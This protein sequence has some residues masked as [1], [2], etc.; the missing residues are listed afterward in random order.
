MRVEHQVPSMSRS[1]VSR[2]VLLRVS[3]WWCHQWGSIAEFL[4]F[5]DRNF[6]S[7]FIWLNSS[8]CEVVRH[9]WLAAVLWHHAEDVGISSAAARRWRQ[10]TTP[11][12]LSSVSPDKQMLGCCSAVGCSRTHLFPSGLFIHVFSLSFPPSVHFASL[13]YHVNRSSVFPSVFSVRW[14]GWRCLCLWSGK[15]RLIFNLSA[16]LLR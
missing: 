8:D 1:W 14:R 16:L 12:F 13:I 7:A 10:K 15:I 5:I 2:H 6:P 11:P 3:P 9:L 4:F